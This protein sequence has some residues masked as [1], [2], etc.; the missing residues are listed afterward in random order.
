MCIFA[1]AIIL[2]WGTSDVFLDIN[3]AYQ[4]NDLGFEAKTR[5]IIYVQQIIET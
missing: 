2:E 1:H 5:H 3:N 4:C